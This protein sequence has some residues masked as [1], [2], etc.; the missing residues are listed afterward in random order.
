MK[1]LHVTDTHG[2]AKNPS[3]RLDVFYVAVIKKFLELTETI[4]REQ[5]DFVIH[6]GD[7][8]H[9]PRVSLKFAGKIAEIMN[10]WGV[11]IY[12]TPGNHDLDGYN[13]QTVD[14]TM[15][16]FLS[17]NGTIQL[18]TRG[19]AEAFSV[20]GASGKEYEL[21][22][23]GQEYYDGIDHGF[24]D[25]YQI[26]PHTADFS[27]MAAHGMLMEAPFFPD[28][29]HTLIK[30][31]VTDAD[32]VLCGH[33]HP[34]FKE[35]Q[36]NGTWF[37]NPG[38]ALR[39]EATAY[40]Q[41]NMPRYLLMD[42]EENATQDGLE[43]VQWEYQ[44][45]RTAQ[46]GSD[47]FDFTHKQAAKTKQKTLLNFKSSIKQAIAL[48]NNN[49]IPNI[50]QLVAQNQ[51]VP[52]EVV[53]GAMDYINQA[54]TNEIDMVPEI[55]GYIEKPNRI[56]LRKAEIHNFQSHKDTVIE[57][58]DGLNV[59]LGETN[60]GKTA[61]VRAVLWALFN[62]PKGTDFIMT[63]EEDC[64]V[65]LTFSDGSAIERSRSVKSAGHYVVTQVDGTSY[66]F[67]GFSNEIPV[68]V[69]NE[70]QMPEVYL[71]K[72]VKARL[73]V[74][75]QM[76]APFLLSESPQVK[77]A[78][79]GRIIGTQ[80]VDAAIKTVNRDTLASNK[81]AKDLSQQ[82]D[83]WNE[84][85]KQ[86]QDLSSTKRYIDV[87]EAFISEKEAGDREVSAL[88]QLDS[89]YN[90]NKMQI[91]M[92]AKNLA[93]IPDL[94][95]IEP[96]IE[97]GL[98]LEEEIRELA[99]QIERLRKVALAKKE[100][101]RKL[102]AL[103]D[104][105]LLVGVVVE[106]EERIKEVET[107]H[108]IRAERVSVYVKIDRLN[109]ALMHQDA[110]QLDAVTEGM[111]AAL[112]RADASVHSLKDIRQLVQE[113]DRLTKAQNAERTRGYDLADKENMNCLELM[114]AEEDVIKA[115]GNSCPFCGG[116]L[117][118]EHLQHVLEG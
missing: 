118:G 68:Q 20:I 35:V 106:L 16:G 97:K 113:Q 54:K 80:V 6:T 92:T 30:D 55:K 26:S 94:S 14:Q 65:K 81:R 34:G 78:A 84:E 23:E 11:P 102:Q 31:V 77:A 79:V 63:G 47:V 50:L 43:L 74:S 41:T 45:F 8:F 110:S 61:V 53:Q 95:G 108:A 101:K 116:E 112:L 88:A 89:L 75:S 36:Q 71:T 42:I 19:D 96:D 56:T 39:L 104:S 46:P 37:F 7:L 60:K 32:I 12:V 18:L 73:N 90:G 15:L 66:S 117:T 93:R 48:Q 62:D 52:A 70:H 103:P 51:S 64:S 58:D 86:Y 57:F 38:S 59:I 25:D 87:L 107:I 1:I 28:L 9:S 109:K 3:G 114:S 85:L 91:E 67:K 24:A 105:Q 82:I 27:I 111:E 100:T 5:V 10:S 76:D 98:A 22:V 40:N 115:V 21:L 17:K 13:L 2:T 99:R 83:D 49:T 29:P 44:S 69:M 4:K 72:D 33:Y